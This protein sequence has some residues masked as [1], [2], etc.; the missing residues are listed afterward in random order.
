MVV[1]D[2]SQICHILSP[3]Y[4][5]ASI[6]IS[7]R[8][9]T[10]HGCQM[11]KSS[12]KPE[13]IEQPKGGGS[14]EL[15]DATHETRAGFNRFD[16]VR[17]AMTAQPPLSLNNIE[18]VDSAKT[19]SQQH[20][21]NTT[22]KTNESR[23]LK[24]RLGDG[25]PVGFVEELG[26]GIEKRTSQERDGQISPYDWSSG[27]NELPMDE[28]GRRFGASIPQPPPDRTLKHDKDHVNLFTDEKG[29]ISG[30]T[31]LSRKSATQSSFTL[32][33]KGNVSSRTVANLS[34]G[35]TETVTFG[36]DGK[37][38]SRERDT[39]GQGLK[40]LPVDRSDSVKSTWTKDGKIASITSTHGQETTKF[41][42]KLDG[43]T[44]L[45]TSRHEEGMASRNGLEMGSN[46]SPG[47]Y[48][49]KTNFDSNGEENYSFTKNLDARGKR[50][51]EIVKTPYM[52]TT[53]TFDANGE[54]AQ[55]DNQTIDSLS[56]R[57]IFPDRTEVMKI[58]TGGEFT[59]SIDRK[60]DSRSQEYLNLNTGQ[61]ETSLKKGDAMVTRTQS[62][63]E[64]TLLY[65]ENGKWRRHSYN[66]HTGMGQHQFGD[67]KSGS[68]PEWDVGI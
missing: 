5:A 46:K 8:T 12:T 44:G 6:T 52:I 67:N 57:K 56:R 42:F 23:T 14:S 20:T 17:T 58:T 9:C 50:Q 31:S 19:D 64:D 21:G 47:T 3:D 54:E 32:D 4:H 45:T 18:I 55:I 1:T 16:E 35:S 7:G 33:G 48:E 59:H 53:S 22:E 60:D 25:S 63:K 26:D 15:S 43:E 24:E 68:D 40:K 38:L 2:L 37:P 66:P 51:S 41:K 34:D 13:Q 28:L 39:P 65:N 49:S 36:K 11:S 61:K 62:D 27:M 10:F 30:L 29:N